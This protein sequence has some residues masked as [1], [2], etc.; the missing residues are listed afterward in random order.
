MKLWLSLLMGLK[1]IAAHKFRSGLTMLGII[2]GVA[3]LLTTFALTAGIAHGMRDF[4]TQI[5]GIEKI[6]VTRQD[7]PEE[8]TSF[9]EISPGATVAD[10][11]IIRRRADLVSY[12]SPVSELPAALTRSNQTF[13]AQVYGCWPDFAYINKHEVATGRML[14]QIDLDEARHVCLVGRTIVEKLFLGRKDY[15]AVGE[16][17]LINGRPFTIVGIFNFYEREEDKLRRAR[18]EP[19]KG[20]QPGRGAGGGGGGN[21]RPGGGWDPF[22]R[23]NT[24][25]QIPITTMFYDYKSANVVGLVDQGPNYKL[26]QLIFQVNDVARFQDAIEQTRTLLGVTHRGIDDFSFN[27]REEWFDNMERSIKSTRI[28]GGLIAVISL[29]VGGIGITNIMLASITERIREIGVRRAIGAKG[30]DIFLQIIVESS[31]I[32]ICGGVLGLAASA[33]LMRLLATLTDSE[34]T[35][36]V[37]PGAILISFSFA[38]AIGVL[39]GFYPAI[40]ASRLDPIEA[41]RYG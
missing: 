9:A 33:G 39:S 17:I 18:G 7:P 40:K 29:I 38:V 21:R 11:E 37:E 35:P 13:R 2:L 34:N 3:S 27:T 23:K 30:R 22:F 10:A 5:G 12:V 6:D 4:M 32:G 31:V 8:Q 19:P 1:E 20:P 15:N 25:V 36:I 24:S 26:D 14:S 28:S 16:S 41:L